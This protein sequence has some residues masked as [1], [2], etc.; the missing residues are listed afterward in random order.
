M[1][2][3]LLSFANRTVLVTGASSGIGA[4]TAEMMAGLAA[5][6]AIVYH[7]NAAGAEDVCRRITASGGR[8]VPI[9]GDLSRPDEIRGVV[10]RA[11]EALGSIDV[12]VNNAGG[13][14]GRFGIRELT[15]ERL[16]AVLDLNLKSA[17]FASQAVAEEMIQRRR[18]AIVN[19]SSIAAH[20]GGGPGAG[21]Y[22]AAKAALIAYTKSLA[23]ELAPNG[24]RV[25]AVAPGSIEFP[26]GM[27]ERRKTEN[28]DLYKRVFDSIPFGRLGRPEEVANVVLFLASPLA[29]WV[30]GQTI[31]VDGGQILSG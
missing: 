17:V 31:V 9:R 6:V 3:S 10:A 22:A 8:A 24:I 26:G 27:W 5:A 1:A 2:N 25:N 4:A 13:I 23:K 7:G 16:D 11:R 21:P 12:L 28:P 29:S 18:G 20:H 15:P 30:T 14:V 19:V